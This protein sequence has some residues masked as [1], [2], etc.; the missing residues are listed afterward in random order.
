MEF[1]NREWV[2]LTEVSEGTARDDNPPVETSVEPPVGR[3]EPS[4]AATTLSRPTA[5]ISDELQVLSALHAIGADLGD[6]VDVSLNAD[7][8]VVSGVGIPPQ[9]QR[10]IHDVLDAMPHVSVEFSEPGQTPTPA[11]PAVSDAASGGTVPAGIRQRLERQLGGQAEFQRFASQL[12]DRNESAMARAYALRKLAQ[13]FPD[14][15]EAAM[16]PV[17]RQTLRSM[18]RE[19]ASAMAVEVAAIGHVLTPVLTSAG[20]TAAQ[21]QPAGSAAWQ[22]AAEELLRRARRV[23]VLLSMLMGAAPGDI[24]A[25]RLPSELLTALNSLGTQLD[26]CRR[27]LAQ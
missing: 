16:A 14:A 24:P 6:P 4:R 25:E 9:R 17:D 10:Q 3:P 23:E 18:A 26:E 21:T 13:R 15:A 11:E 12:L 8:V 20:G 19:H 7:K 27:L 2:E 1:R 5:S 22:P